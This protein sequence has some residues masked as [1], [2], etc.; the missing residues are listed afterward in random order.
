MKKGTLFVEVAA[1]HRTSVT[2]VTL[3][4]IG[5]AALV[6]PKS[7]EPKREPLPLESWVDVDLPPSPPPPEPEPKEKPKGRG[8]R[9]LGKT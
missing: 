3:V 8:R 9:R 4:A 6:R 7:K 1:S 2:L 5:L